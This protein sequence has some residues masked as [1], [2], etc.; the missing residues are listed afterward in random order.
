MSRVIPLGYTDYHFD[1]IT[2]N[3]LLTEFQESDYT[4]ILNLIE[5]LKDDEFNYLT[6]LTLTDLDRDE[7]GFITEEEKSYLYNHNNILKYY[8]NQIKYAERVL[9]RYRELELENDRQ[10]E[11][12][13]NNVIESYTDQQEGS[14]ETNQLNDLEERLTIINNN[15]N[16]ISQLDFSK[17][18]LNTLENSLN[19]LRR[20]A[21]ERDVV[22]K[23]IYDVKYKTLDKEQ[24]S[25][26][27]D[28][29]KKRTKEFL[30]KIVI[31][32]EN[33]QNQ[34][35]NKIDMYESDESPIP[36]TDSKELDDAKKLL[37]QITEQLD[38]KYRVLYELNDLRFEGKGFILRDPT[39]NPPPVR[40][41]LNKIGQE[42]VSSVK[43]IRT[44]LSMSTKIL[45]NIASFGQLQE[46]MKEIGIDELFH[47]SMLINGKY[48]LE[49][50]EVIKMRV[51]PKAVKSN[52][53]VLDI[54]I[55]RDITIQQMMDNTQ[56][57]MG[58]NYGSYDAKSNNC[59][60][61]LSN[62]LS[63]NG[64]SNENTNT[65]INQKTEE[66]FNK[67]P[68][69]SKKIVDLGTTAGAV[70]ERQIS[71]EGVNPEIYN[72]AYPRCKVKF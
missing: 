72:F 29:R 53:E 6:T 44:P 33:L 10:K 16:A 14:G 55:S 41:L 37:Q 2:D 59:S 20:F 45:L 30:E 4:D 40:N 27:N 32:L 56:K 9:K 24:L 15:I 51:N 5:E 49:K 19:Q 70:A 52:S 21:D 26:E 64:L 69:L 11:Q 63:S 7:D 71:G 31:P 23:N 61:F 8:Q 54:P 48:E 3:Y 25:R 28:M 58:Q 34:V 38:G 42:K 66:L 35:Q 18:P 67:F 57:Q 36:A 47:L 62:V 13:D 1:K 43:L 60:V 17:L 68:S 50:N 39:L 22:E 65:F 46:K 12:P